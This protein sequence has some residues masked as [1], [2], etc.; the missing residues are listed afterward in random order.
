[1]VETIICPGCGREYSEFTWLHPVL[2]I[3]SICTRK[4]KYNKTISWDP[5]EQEWVEVKQGLE[6]W[7]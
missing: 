4:H 6:R 2:R 7:L 3:C 5:E 1:M